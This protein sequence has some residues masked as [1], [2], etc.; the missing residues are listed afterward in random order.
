MVG[1]REK[2][3]LK[4]GDGLSVSLGKKETGYPHCYFFFFRFSWSLFN[5]D[6]SV[7]SFSS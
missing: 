1:I 5:V 3:G 2:N 6:R 7:E 4:H